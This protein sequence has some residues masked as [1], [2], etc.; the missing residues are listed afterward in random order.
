MVYKRLIIYLNASH[1]R[2]SSLDF[3]SDV[4]GA[5]KV[6]SVFFS[7]CCTVKIQHSN[8]CRFHSSQSY[9]VLYIVSAFSVKG[10]KFDPELSF[11]FHSV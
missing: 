10:P 6:Y 3:S 1:Q 9:T 8:H 2:Y 11:V 4:H 7:V 5:I